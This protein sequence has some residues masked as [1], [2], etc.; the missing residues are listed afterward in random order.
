VIFPHI[1][2][3]GSFFWGED[4]FDD[5]THWFVE[6][7]RAA[8]A[9]PRLEWVVKLHP[10]HLVKA[11]K[12]NIVSRPQ[13]LEVIEQAL[14]SLP[15]HVKLVHP[16]TELST[17]SLFEIADYA[18]TVRGTVGIESALFGIPVVT[19]GTGRY[20]HR[21]FTLDSLTRQEYLQ[22]LATLETYPRLSAEQVELAERFA[23]GVFF[24]RPVR[25]SSESLEYE[26]DAAASL[27]VAI[28]CQDR[29][30][31]LASP[32]MRQL[33]SWIAEGKAED[34]LVLPS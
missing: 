10:A 27:N 17:Y 4:L 31:W 11:R 2:W 23:Y 33:A 8:C 15:A 25:L 24:C 22:K 16:E 5:Y 6:T 12:E 9:N 30:Q 21:G 32:D 20:A 13:E 1:L 34:M 26:R 18:V 3:D 28:H 14:G 7:I 29:Q 19:A